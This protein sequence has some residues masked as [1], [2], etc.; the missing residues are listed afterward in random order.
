MSKIYKNEFTSEISFPLGGIGTGTIG[1]SGYGALID[2]EIHNRPNRESI[3]S[4]TNFAIKAESADEV[5]DMRLLQGDIYRDF[6]GGM[7]NGHHSWGYG[8]GTNRGTMAG[9]KHFESTA[10]RGEFPFAEITFNDH[11]FPGEVV[12]EGFN[13]FIPLN[14][15]DSS[16]P[17]AFFNVTVENTTDEM[18][19]YTVAF[20]VTNPLKSPGINR[21][22]KEDNIQ[23]IVMNSLEANEDHEHFGNVAIGT[24]CDDATY[25]E[26]WYRGGWFDNVMMFINDFESYGP[27]K[28]RTYE[29]KDEAIDDTCT[30]AGTIVVLPGEKKNIRFNLAWFI[31]NYKKYWK[32]NAKLTKDPYWKNYYAKNFKSA[33][34]VLSYSFMNWDRLYNDT[35]LFKQTL[36]ASDLPEVVTDAIQGNIA[37]L[38]SL[39]CLRLTDGEFYGWEG[40]NKDEGS[41]EGSCQHVWNYAYALPFLFPNLERSMRALEIKYNMTEI[42]KL[43]FRL[44]LPLGNEMQSFRACVDG[45]FGTIMKFYREWK[46]SGDTAWLKEHWDAIKTCMAYT[47]HKDNPDLWDI[48][49]TGILHGRQHHTLDVELYGVHSWLTGYYHGALLATAEMARAFDEIEYANELEAMFEKGK[50]WL[51]EHTFNGDYFVQKLD[52]KSRTILDKYGGDESIN[53]VGGYWDDENMQIK[54]QVGDGCEIDLVVADWHADNMGLPH[55]YFQDERK[56]SLEALYKIN[57]VTLRDI[58]NPCRIFGVDGEKGLLMCNWP[59]DKEQP[60]ITVP[61]TQ[62][63]MSGF[64][65]AAACNMLQVGMEKEALEIITAIRER[66]DGNKRNPWAEIECGSNYARAMASYSLLLTYSGFK[67]DLT[68]NRIGFKPIHHGNFFWS[69]EGAWGNVNYKADTMTIE[70]LYGSIKLKEIVHPYNKIS[71][72]LINKRTV[73][74]K[75]EKELITIS[76]IL[77][78]GDKITLVMK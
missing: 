71:E 30:V 34:D 33:K 12:M 13:P 49:K 53:M 1:L 54:Y 60:K 22:V 45:Q 37:T 59:K 26:Y 18:L 11:N 4:F 9:L 64:E 36:F 78:K 77:N 8:H 3:N 51:S 61:Y 66:Y 44:M 39:T 27:L 75:A 17:A 31:P 57:F 28:N 52:Y 40:V 7:H 41:C 74:F 58:H 68:K 46:I 42:G 55:I 47:W 72:V 24:D 14:D 56:K 67:Y 15:Y 16:L 2:W 70:V 32:G 29:G 25:Q 50:A 69:I 62:E 23:A 65:Y 19:K 43:S 5:L 73:D 48:N 63:V 35:K 6:I 76:E 38:K 10:F 21:Q 20:S